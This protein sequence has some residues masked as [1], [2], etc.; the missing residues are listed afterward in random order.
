MAATIDQLA[1]RTASY[2]RV[3]ENCVE[4][5]PTPD[6]AII[7][8]SKRPD[9]GTIEFSSAQWARFVHEA[10][11]GSP[12]DNGAVIVKRMSDDG[13]A[14]VRSLRDGLELVYDAGEWAAF[15]DG[16]RDGEFDFRGSSLA[17]L[18]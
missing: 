14:I 3:A 5:A 16:A 17:E 8:H 13:G 11:T 1:W 12:S 10:R 9:A 4:V 18:G 6:G 7:R 15:V 2:T